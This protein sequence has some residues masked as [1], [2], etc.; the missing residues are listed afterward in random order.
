[1]D[2]SFEMRLI[3]LNKAFPNI[4][5]AGNFRPVTVLSN[6]FKFLEA[7]FVKKLANYCRYDLDKE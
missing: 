7:P 4:P 2:K 6:L 1:M 5:E 3:P